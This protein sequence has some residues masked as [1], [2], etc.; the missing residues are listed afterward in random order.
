MIE[1]RYL[2]HQIPFFFGKNYSVHSDIYHNDAYPACLMVQCGINMY[3]GMRE[4]SMALT[5]LWY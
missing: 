3:T 1:M 5:M 2:V 4:A